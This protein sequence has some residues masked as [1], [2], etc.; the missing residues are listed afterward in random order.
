MNITGNTILITGAG[1]GMG[2]EAARQFSELGNTVIMVARNADRLAE[3]AGSLR[4]AYTFPCDITDAAQVHFLLAYLRAEH[5]QLNIAFLNAGV[6]HNY[7]LFS[8]TDAYAHAA[9][10]VDTNFLSII[11]LTQE[12]EPVLADKAESALVITTS[13]AA[14]VP[15][16]SNPTYSATKAA[17][18]SLVMS[19]RASLDRKNS[20]IKLFE[21]IAPLVD[22]PF[23]QEVISDQK[24]PAKDVIEALIGGL[25]QDETELR[26]GASEDLYQ[27]L[28]RSPQEA[29]QLANAIT[30]A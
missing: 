25:E 21:L 23:S 24:M 28:R 20:P 19:M 1:T 16:V 15:D 3:E 7:R 10:E 14:Y 9:Q 18:H 6:T 13:A 30:N 11:R 26:V 17:L 27:A 22:S 5:P 2:L 4:N 12:L 8:E 29:M